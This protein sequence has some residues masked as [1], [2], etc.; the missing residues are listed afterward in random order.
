MREL[1]ASCPWFVI[2]IFR[3]DGRLPRKAAYRLQRSATPHT[4][5]DTLSNSA[6]RLV[7]HRHACKG[8]AIYANAGSIPPSC[9]S[10]LPQRAS[11]RDVAIM[12]QVERS[13]CSL[14]LSF[15]R[16]CMTDLRSEEAAAYRKLYRTARWRR[17]RERQLAHQP[18]CQWCLE[19]DTVEPATEVHHLI[20]HRGDLD[21]FWSGPFLS[22]CTPCHATRGQREDRG[23]LVQTFG[24]DG[25]PPDG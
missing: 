1:P 8:L 20:A 13:I 22:T 3:R 17:L 12:R 5:P 11:S 6:P 18:L 25:W 16:V 2:G 7:T 19:L 21:L 10:P 14:A 4:R 9:R 23:Q 15:L 24:V